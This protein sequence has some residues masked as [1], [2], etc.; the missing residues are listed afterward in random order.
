MTDQDHDIQEDIDFKKTILRTFTRFL[1]EGEM[2]SINVSNLTPKEVSDRMKSSVLS[3]N[4]SNPP[5][6]IK[7]FNG[8]YPER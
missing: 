8:F 2:E 3:M 5:N 7:N 6:Q 1:Q 4:I